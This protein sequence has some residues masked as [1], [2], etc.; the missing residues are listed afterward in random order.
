[1]I[2]EYLAWGFAQ[3]FSQNAS[4]SL[5]VLAVFWTCASQATAR[6]SFPLFSGIA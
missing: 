4:P 5:R 6:H 2:R 1:M 3:R